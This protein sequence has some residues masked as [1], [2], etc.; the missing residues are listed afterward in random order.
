MSYGETPSTDF[1]L[2]LVVGRE[3]NEDI[4]ATADCGDYNFLGKRN[5]GAF[6]NV[7]TLLV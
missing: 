2:F 4:P 5:R 6:W 7:L 3:P 1:P